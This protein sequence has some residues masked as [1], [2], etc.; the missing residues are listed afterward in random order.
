MVMKFQPFGEGTLFDLIV[1]E[2]Q[3]LEFV[4]FEMDVLEPDFP[5][6]LIP[7]SLLVKLLEII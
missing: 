6:R 2:K 4:S 3:I 1:Q 7:E 5:G